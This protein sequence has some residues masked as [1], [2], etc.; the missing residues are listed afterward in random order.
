MENKMKKILLTLLT[1]VI[2]TGFASAQKYEKSVDINGG[3][4][5]D[6]FS[7]F[8]YGV[9]LNNGICFKD[10]L[11]VGVGFG[12]RQ[13][14]ALLKREIHQYKQDDELPVDTKETFWGNTVIPV[15]ATVKLDWGRAKSGCLLRLDAGVNN[16]LE[17]MDYRSVSGLFVEPSVGYGL[18]I[19][20]NMKLEL[21]VG[22][23]LQKMSYWQFA[24]YEV[25][26]VVLNQEVSGMAGTLNVHA[27]IAF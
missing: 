25:V 15:F 11:Y 21:S 7:K 27:G 10:F 23:N 2:C 24:N 9:T 26:G 8:S 18:K 6:E 14:D 16:N 4:G 19:A 1:T 12:M 20:D 22:Y 13:T 3:P 5:L 17:E